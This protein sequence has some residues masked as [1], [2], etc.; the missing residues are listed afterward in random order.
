MYQNIYSDTNGSSTNARMF[1]IQYDG[2]CF[3][4]PAFGMALIIIYRLG[5]TGRTTYAHNNYIEILV[6][7]GIVGLLRIIAYI[8]I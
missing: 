7:L 3:Q 4:R 5:V 1:M 6:G 2:N 8:F